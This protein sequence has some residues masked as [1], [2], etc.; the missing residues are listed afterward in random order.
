MQLQDL[1]IQGRGRLSSLQARYGGYL[2]VMRLP[3]RKTV[4]TTS[5][6]LQA[7]HL[8]GAAG[9][10][11]F[12]WAV[13]ESIGWNA[14][15]FLGA[16]FLGALLAYNLDRF[17]LKPA[18]EWNLPRR[19]TAMKHLRW[20]ALAV[21]L[22]AGFL[23]LWLPWQRGDWLVLSLAVLGSGVCMGYSLPFFERRCK[24]KPLLKTFLVPSL[25][26]LAII[27]PPLFQQGLP[28]H[29][30]TLLFGLLWSWSVLFC[31]MMLCDLRDLR[32]H[33]RTG[34]ITLPVF[35]GK[36]RTVR[37]LWGLVGCIFGLATMLAMLPGATS[38]RLWVA[39]A[40]LLSAY[41]AWLVWSARTR[42]RKHFYEWWV[43]GAL[44]IPAIIRFFLA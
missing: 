12:G 8:Y 19:L 21:A 33:Q 43:E 31:H 40:L 25:I 15:P 17:R 14:R 37:L 10:M 41:L 7:L 11:A 3:R 38:R 32:G 35:M 26:T 2:P 13:A 28:Q 22:A 39:Y 27:L 44:F 36:Q 9:I 18:D 23:L 34:V 24:E 20:A 6:W 42:R 1:I 30:G 4:R 29:V 5:M 16:W